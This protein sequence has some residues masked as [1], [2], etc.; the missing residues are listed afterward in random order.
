MTGRPARV[1]WS[2]TSTEAKN[3]S[4]STCR[5]QGVSLRSCME[6]QPA[7]TLGKGHPG[8]AALFL[9]SAPYGLSGPAARPGELGAL[10]LHGGGLA[11]DGLGHVD[12]LIG[13]QRAG[14]EH[15]G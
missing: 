5:M 8:T 10:A 2:R 12:P 13:L 15:G 9:G 14:Q 7:E 11:L 4:M 3:A 6:R 1:G